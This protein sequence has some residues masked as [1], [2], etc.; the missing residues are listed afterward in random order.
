MK[1]KTVLNYLSLA[2]I[3]FLSGC[4]SAPQ[5]GCPSNKAW[6][7]AGISAEQTRR[8]LA[9]CQYEAFLEQRNGDS[10][11]A[12]AD[13][14]KAIE[15][16]PDFTEV[17]AIRGEVKKL[18]GDLDGALTDYNKSIE[19]NPK[20]A[21]VYNRRGCLNY[22][23]HK[24]TDALA[25]FRKSC[26]S[27]SDAKLLD[28]SHFY[29]WLIQAQLGEKD[30]ATKELQTYLDNRKTGTP[31][32]WPSKVA[33]FLTAQLTEPDF[34]KESENA[35]KQTDRGQHCEAYFYAGSKRLIEGDKT[36]A[37]DYFNK[38]LATGCK[39]FDEYNSAAVKLKS[40]EASK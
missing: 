28:Y 31:G 6:Y 32:D 38:C 9:A 35:D 10:D 33:R 37:T 19:M 21:P 8:D 36:T 14:N 23:L 20:L 34:F 22:D 2:I 39:E 13:F 30:A 11:A 25:D 15:I 3:I 12:L 1:I 7:Q 4:A 24:F 17:Y 40:L 26:D 16:K 5:T 18:K 29:I 27:N